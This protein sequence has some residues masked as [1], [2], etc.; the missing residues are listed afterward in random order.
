MD[1]PEHEDDPC[2]DHMRGK[3]DAVVLPVLSGQYGMYVHDKAA[4]ADEKR[5]R[6]EGID[7]L[8]LAAHPAA[9]VLV[10][11][12]SGKCRYRHRHKQGDQK[13]IFHLNHSLFATQ[14]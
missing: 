11:A 4:H 14:K 3:H 7:Q 10:V 1:V 12:E 6:P 13:L 2:S 5:H 8:V 9:S